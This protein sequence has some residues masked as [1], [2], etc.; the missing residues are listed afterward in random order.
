MEQ[1]LINIK[2]RKTERVDK[3]LDEQSKTNS[4]EVCKRRN[5]RIV[6]M[7][8]S[9]LRSEYSVLD[10]HIVKLGPQINV[11]LKTDIEY[12]IYLVSKRE[13]KLHIFL[14]NC[15]KDDT[16][17][18][19]RYSTDNK[20]PELPQKNNTQKYPKTDSKGR[21]EN[22]GKKAWD[23]VLEPKDNL[24]EIKS[25]YLK[26][27]EE[28]V[29]RISLVRSINIPQVDRIIYEDPEARDC[30]RQTSEVVR[31]E[32][33][34]LRTEKTTLQIIS[35]ELLEPDQQKLDS[36]LRFTLYK[37]DKQ[38]ED[39]TRYLSYCSTFG[40]D[41]NNPTKSEDD[42]RKI[43]HHRKPPK[44]YSNSTDFD[45]KNRSTDKAP[46]NNT[47]IDKTKRYYDLRRMEIFERIM[48]TKS[49]HTYKIDSLAEELPTPKHCQR[50][51]LNELTK[52]EADFRMEK[53]VMIAEMDELTQEDKENHKSDIDFSLNSIDYK[54]EKIVEYK[55][56]CSKQLEG[57]D[58]SPK[59]PE[60]KDNQELDT[61]LERAYSRRLKDFKKKIYEAIHRSNSRVEEE[62]RKRSTGSQI[63]TRK[64][65][66]EVR[67]ERDAIVEEKTL[68]IIE[69]NYLLAVDQK[70]LDEKFNKAINLLEA[71]VAAI[72]KYLNRCPLYPEDKPNP[73]EPWES[74]PK[75]P[76][77]GDSQADNRQKKYQKDDDKKNPVDRIG[78]SGS[79]SKPKAKPKLPGE[80]D[81][82]ADNR[83]KKYQKD[84]DKKNPVDRI[85]DSG[86]P[87]KPKAKPKL[88]G[89]GDSQADNRQKKYQKDD[90]KKNPVDRIG[91]SGSPSKPKAT[92]TPSKPKGSE[93]TSR[94]VEIYIQRTIRITQRI[95]V[96]KRRRVKE[97][98][99]ILE[100][101]PIPKPDSY[102]QVKAEILVAEMRFL[103]QERT[104]LQT[105]W[106]SLLSK[107]QNTLVSDYRFVQYK[108]EKKLTDISMYLKGCV[109]FVQESFIPANPDK[110]PSEP[111]IPSQPSKPRPEAPT[112]VKR[113]LTASELKLV[114]ELYKKRLDEY[115]IRLK[116]IHQEKNNRVE[117]LIEQ[118]PE[119]KNC[120]KDDAFEVRQ[121][122][123]TIRVDRTVI[124]SS[125]QTMLEE[126]Q[127]LVEVEHRK[128][129]SL[130][131]VKLDKMERYLF[132]CVYDTKEP[133]KLLEPNRNIEEPKIPIS[134][135]K[136]TPKQKNKPWN[137]Y[138]TRRNNFK[139]ED[140]VKVVEI[141]EKKVEE[142]VI[143]ITLV[144][145][146][147]VTA[148]E[149]MLQDNTFTS[150][151][152]HK[153]REEIEKLK[154]ERI[155][156]LKAFSELLVA[157][158]QIYREAY[159]KAIRTLEEK[160][161][162]A[163]KFLQKCPDETK[164]P[165]KPAEPTKPEDLS[166]KVYEK[167][168]LEFITLIK[169]I[170]VRR[171]YR[172]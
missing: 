12:V 1:I 45:S 5:L 33:E 62:V 104:S 89:E 47:T 126:D 144:D 103:L 71:K 66:T 124:I 26:R 141:Y 131:D 98:E 113:T 163:E 167:R 156:I 112:L 61:K 168:I 109:E 136:G 111:L 44:E 39:F 30:T 15:G 147:T 6:N 84:D 74:K 50:V 132:K 11:E 146:K 65:V 115:L 160:I 154:T 95:I 25:I 51:Y 43:E 86:S 49:N 153:V 31:V 99:E 96:L 88:P 122:E 135:K 64:E 70:S 79:P 118:L 114:E 101:L 58:K 52:E 140:T 172:S 48:R 9:Q 80:G 38:I 19:N 166:K 158:Q 105:E 69:W 56:K 37:V 129:I 40:M 68:L 110:E 143:R 119:P 161:A 134:P 162:D 133:L 91:D 152:A 128:A 59:K 46:S 138:H 90:D 76:G 32:V 142:I 92:T 22:S 149:S 127:K 81:S 117:K 28:V 3:V 83:Q 23:E 159:I 35:K 123:E 78:D 125:F 151:K 34:K 21:Q 60:S 29:K 7:E 16:L 63:P 53:M 130:I 157:D 57:T 82:Q 72:E 145:S 75:L 139:P 165:V 87:S 108:I 171:G 55:D 106:R 8:L 27:V 54:L 67:L 41:I 148:V 102:T 100:E 164:E 20:H 18:Q 137:D 93:N 4:T 42:A 120:T 14:Q 85:G 116:I 73:A 97:V 36:E 17:N 94:I 24:Q 150:F 10:E 107:E 77:E 2:G 170:R 13:E 121:E 155:L 169:E